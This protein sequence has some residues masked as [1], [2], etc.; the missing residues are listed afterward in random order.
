M[1]T[2]PRTTPNP[3][4]EGAEVLVFASRFETRTLWGALKF[5][6]RTP[7]VWRQ[8]GRAPGAYGA[9]L[10]AAP[11]KRTFWTL[12]AWESREA[13]KDFAASA[14]HGPAAGGLRGQMKDSEFL[15]WK[16]PAGDLPLDW[17]DALRRFR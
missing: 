6:A 11:L 12:S 1:P 9:T 8:V 14:P 10:K 3:P 7:T 2:L 4:P 13:L 16:A 15:T 5:F 17:E